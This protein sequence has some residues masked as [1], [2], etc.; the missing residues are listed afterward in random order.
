VK[1]FKFQGERRE[2]EAWGDRKK[3]IGKTLARK[4]ELKGDPESGN[5]TQGKGRK[6]ERYSTFSGGKIQYG[7]GGGVE[8]ME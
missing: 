6:R 2:R 4:N 7:K 3:G 8:A 5:I 1:S